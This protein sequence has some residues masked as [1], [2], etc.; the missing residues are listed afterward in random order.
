MLYQGRTFKVYRGM[1]SLGAMVQ[2]LERTL[3]P[4]GR[5]NART[6]NWCPKGS[7]AA[8][9]SKARSARLCISS[10]AACGPAWA[11]AAP[12]RST[13]CAR[14]RDSFKSRR[15]VCGRVI[16]MTLPSRRKHRTTRPNTRRGMNSES[17]GSGVESQATDFNFDLHF[18]ACRF[19]I[20]CLAIVPAGGD[21]S[22]GEL[23][24]RKAGRSNSSRSANSQ[25]IRASSPPSR[26][27]PSPRR[28]ATARSARSRFE[29][30]GRAEFEGPA[31]AAT[32]SRR[33]ADAER[34][35][36]TRAQPPSRRRPRHRPFGP[37]AVPTAGR[38]G[39]PLQRA[40]HRAVRPA[41]DRTSKPNRPKS[42][43]TKKK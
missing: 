38:T 10:S 13:N 9:R 35:R 40:N 27:S 21:A 33:H 26:N 25:P 1:G 36:R 28:A 8:C 29:D 4:G 19:S 37:A 32:A 15:P 6:E 34:G 11:T 7:K 24:W 3:P 42:N 17:R 22:A 16:H 20:A 5:G 14:K 31:F 12:K 43:S 30:D 18:A 23:Q 39:Q 41:A 2:G